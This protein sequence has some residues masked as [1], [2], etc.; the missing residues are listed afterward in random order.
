VR[1]SRNNLAPL[2]ALEPLL[3]LSRAA[4]PDVQTASLMYHEVLPDGDPHDAW[5]VVRE[6]AFRTQMLYLRE[7]FNILSLDE[8][9]QRMR[10]PGKGRR[11]MA[12]VTFDDGYKGNRDVVLPIIETLG[13]PI[14]VFVAT[15]A[16]EDG[17]SY[18]FDRVIAAL[19]SDG[20]GEIDLR[21]R[22][23]GVYR[24]RDFAA[25]ESR[26]V[27]I[28]RALTDLKGL[29][30]VDLDRAVSDLLGQVGNKAEAIQPLALL[31]K[32]DIREMARSRFVTFGAHSHDHPVLPL[33]S[34]GEV[35]DSVLKSKR[36]LEEWTGKAVRHFAYPHGMFTPEI[37]RIV[38]ECGFVS[39]QA[40]RPALWRR[41]DF[42]LAIPRVAV[43]RYD[44]LA[45]FRMRVSGIPGW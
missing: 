36:L 14:T 4:R 17:S 9:L 41:G 16:I 12:A 10:E 26:W 35:R 15:A 5:I 27:E 37:A 24:P 38:Q 22:G 18:W 20:V 19:L 2:V 28:Q 3:A 29:P 40:T 42:D 45:L 31:S 23:L 30:P 32:S 13:I 33:L 7:R 8:L 11:C 21:A 34:P 6:S 1:L 44:S 43:G 25:G 39:S